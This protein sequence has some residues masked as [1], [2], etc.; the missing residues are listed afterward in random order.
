MAEQTLAVANDSSRDFDAD[1]NPVPEMVARSRLKVD[2]MKWYTS[3]IAAKRW[4]DRLAVETSGEQ[5]LRF[6][7]LHQYPDD[8]AK[9]IS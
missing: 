8:A 9:Q 5:T 1:G 6:V 7:V 2:T 4:G 3:K